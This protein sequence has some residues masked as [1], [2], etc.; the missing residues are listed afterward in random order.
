MTPPLTPR[1]IAGI[2]IFVAYMLTLMFVVF[3]LAVML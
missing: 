3:R 2:I 1:Q